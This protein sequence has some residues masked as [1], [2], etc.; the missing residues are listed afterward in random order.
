MS[1]LERQRS[2]LVVLDP[3]HYMPGRHLVD[4]YALHPEIAAHIVASIGVEQFGQREYAETGDDFVLT[5]RPETT[6]IF[7]QDNPL[8][9]SQAIAAITAENLPRTEVRVPARGQGQWAGSRRRR[10]EAG[11]SRL[12]HQHRDECLLVH[13]AGH[14]ELRQR[15]RLPPDRRAGA[16]HRRA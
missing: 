5:G 3:Q 11:H 6:L 13:G 8:L 12:R 15:A 4:W 14:R 9:V 1:P 16:P 2:L 10:A 7:A